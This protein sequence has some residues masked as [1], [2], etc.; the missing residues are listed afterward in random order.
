MHRVRPSKT[1]TGLG[2]PGRGP[3]AERPH[4][5]E[6]RPRTMGGP[7]SCRVGALGRAVG[8]RRV[9]GRENKDRNV[10]A[11]GGEAGGQP[12]GWSTPGSLPLLEA[13]A[14]DI[15][16]CLT[17]LDVCALWHVSRQLRAIVAGAE[18]AWW[19]EPWAAHVRQAQGLSRPAGFLAKAV[20]QLHAWATASQAAKFQLLAPV[21]GSAEGC[22]QEEVLQA[23]LPGPLASAFAECSLGRGHFGCSEAV[24]R[25]VRDLAGSMSTAARWG[26]CSYD[27]KHTK[28]EVDGEQGSGSRKEVYAAQVA[29]RTARGGLSLLLRAHGFDFTDAR[30]GVSG[31]YSTVECK[32]ESLAAEPFRVLSRAPPN[33]F[34]L[35]SLLPFFSVEKCTRLFCFR[36]EYFCSLSDSDSDDVFL[37]VNKPLLGQVSDVLLG[38]NKEDTAAVTLHALWRLLCAPSAACP[39][40]ADGALGAAPHEESGEERESSAFLRLRGVF[41]RVARQLGFADGVMAV[42]A[43]PV[44]TD[45]ELAGLSSA[46]AGLAERGVCVEC[47]Y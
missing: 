15:R 1:R 46:L 33:V 6:D 42:G 3:A 27:A 29:V 47:G 43:S 24:S 11:R 31:E 44:E 28:S 16:S 13:C 40:G 14:I 34:L 7:D 18:V 4:A 35:P 37:E 9:D 32:V 17:V 5:P 12:T 2:L 22:Q 21:S 30:S 38:S 19:E 26:R 20:P 36:S 10:R 39:A 8:K 25:A 23:H 41:D 45:Q